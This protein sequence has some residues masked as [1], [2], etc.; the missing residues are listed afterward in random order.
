MHA[1]WRSALMAGA[2]LVLATARVEAQHKSNVALDMGT[3]LPIALLWKLNESVA[4]RPDFSFVRVDQ[5]G[6]NDQWRFGIGA[7][8]L[9]TARQTGSLTT[10]VGARG[11]YSWYSVDNSPTDWAFA[12]IFGGRYAFDQ[13]IGISG[14]TGLAYDRTRIPNLPGTGSRNVSTFGPWGRVSVLLYF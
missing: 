4:I 14:E 12:G 5:G 2:L 1:K 10:Y 3:P 6:G 7:S 11:A 13:H 9:F 8:A